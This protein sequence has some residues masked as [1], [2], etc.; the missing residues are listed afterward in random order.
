MDIGAKRELFLPNTFSE[1]EMIHK[2][3]WRRGKRGKKQVLGTI[4][5]QIKG[6]EGCV[7]CRSCEGN[8][9]LLCL[10]AVLQRIWVQVKYEYS[11]STVME[12]KNRREVAYE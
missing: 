12:T 9:P 2:Y 11:R 10:Y 5:P 8:V 1:Y 7:K 6:K 4:Q 3:I